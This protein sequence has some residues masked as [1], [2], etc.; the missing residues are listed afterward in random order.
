MDLKKAIKINPGNIEAQIT[1]CSINSSQRDFNE[2]LKYCDTAVNMA[3]FPAKHAIITPYIL[4][5]ILFLRAEIY[6]N[7]KEYEKASFDLKKALKKAP[8]DWQDFKKAKRKL[9]NFKKLNKNP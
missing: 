4:A 1:L 3:E 9:E 6:G 7:M 8:V 2:A 5:D